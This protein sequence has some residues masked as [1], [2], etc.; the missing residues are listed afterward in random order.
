MKIQIPEIPAAMIRRLNDHGYEAYVVGGCVRDALLGRAPHDWDICTNAKPTEVIA[1][2]PDKNVAKTGLQHGTVMVIDGGEGY[3][4]TTFRTDGDYSD[5]R[6]PD[7][8]TFVSELREDLARRDFTINAMAYHPDTGVMDYFSGQEDLKNGVIRCVGEAEQRFQEDGLRILRALRFAARFGFSIEEQTGKAMHD[9]RHLLKHIAAER[10]FSEL[11]GFLVG[12]GVGDLLRRYRDIIA[13]ILPPLEKMFDFQQRNP[14]HCYDVWEHTV[15]ALENAEPILP[16]R[17]TMLFHDCGKPDCFSVDERGIGHFYHHGQRS[18]ELTR[19]MLAEL[20]CDN[21]LRDQVL[22]QVEHHDI[23][24]PQTEREGRRFL[25]R[26]GEEGAMFSLAVHRADYMGQ[27][28]EKRPEKLERYEQAKVLLQRLLE[29]QACFTL[30]DLAIKGRDL[31]ALGYQPGP[32]MGNE[33]EALL[34]LVMDGKCPNDPEALR[35][36]AKERMNRTDYSC[37][38]GLEALS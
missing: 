2:F 31:I 23:P 27:A 18:L 29:E 12:K 3:E 17:L 37:K 21:Q 33:L 19:Q 11:K 14:H 35:Q 36:L 13:Q 5:H 20:R 30:K 1:C 25:K 4:I 38:S 8:V 6:H 16:I 22:L 7:Q 34:E 28:P 10:I 15:T 32:A 24:L 26:M 9:C